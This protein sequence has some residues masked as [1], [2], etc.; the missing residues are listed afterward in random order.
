MPT[1]KAESGPDLGGRH[2]P[3][4]VAPRVGIW[5][6]AGISPS[7]YG[8]LWHLLDI[9]IGLRFSGLDIGGFGRIDLSRYNVLIFPPSYGG[10]Y[11]EAFGEEGVERLK[12]WVRAGGTAI[13]IGG[14]GTEFL[15][16]EETKLTQA[17]MRSQALDRFPSVVLGPGATEA[18]RGGA[19]SAVGLRAAPED[20]AD[21]DDDAGE[22][23]AERSSPYDVAPIIGAGA[24]PFIA[25]VDIGTPVAMKPIDLAT[26]L[27]PTLPPGKGK[28][29]KADLERAD[30]RLRRFGPQGTYL[31]VDL[32]ADRWMS[33]GLPDELSALVRARDGLVA[34]PPVQ[35]PARFADIERLHLGGL[36]W[37][38]AAARLAH[39]AYATR[40]RVGRGQVI[41]FVS[42]PEFR[43]WTLATRR[44]LTNAILLGPGLGTDWSTPW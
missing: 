14:G 20:D 39:T 11:G 25:G 21:E 9:E 35:V 3:P 41:L 34:A 15:A 42:P 16:D 37:P 23:S 40:E 13:G 36:L 7:D 30:R 29:D 1:A 6:G 28:P 10:A 27:K 4:L 8:H 26:W 38:E 2:F 31:R 32:D 18:E 12:R 43:G 44:L 19:F 22:E 5:T 33:W 17:R 24:R